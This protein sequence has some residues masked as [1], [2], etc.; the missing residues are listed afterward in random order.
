[1]K[2]NNGC[3]ACWPGLSPLEKEGIMK[4]FTIGLTL[5]ITLTLFAAE[6][7]RAQSYENEQLREPTDITVITVLPS[8]SMA[9][10]LRS[11]AAKRHCCTTDKFLEGAEFYKRAAEHGFDS[12]T[13]PSARWPGSASSNATGATS[14]KLH[15]RYWKL[16]TSHAGAATRSAPGESS[17]RRT[18]WIRTWSRNPSDE[19][20]VARALAEASRNTPQHEGASAAVRTRDWGPSRTVCPAPFLE[21]DSDPTT[22]LLSRAKKDP[23]RLGLLL[24][25]LGYGKTPETVYRLSALIR[26]APRNYG[27]MPGKG[28]SRARL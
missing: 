26:K 10:F 5:G 1:V 23:I 28:G 18:S 27:E 25:L 8:A 21:N 11:E 2:G 17:W 7:L 19:V 14:G 3:P 24:G 20:G 16:P 15:K 13:V 12:S 4:R 9:D 22:S 6:S